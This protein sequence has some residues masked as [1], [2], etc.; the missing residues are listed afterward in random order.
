[1]NILKVING[2]FEQLYR[3][4]GEN[5]LT[6]NSVMICTNNK[7]TIELSIAFYRDTIL[8]NREQ[9]KQLIDTLNKWYEH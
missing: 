4:T 6:D 1:M 7:N 3:P 5:L 8:L 9:T 2:S